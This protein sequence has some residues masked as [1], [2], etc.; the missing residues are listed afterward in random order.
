VIELDIDIKP[1]SDSN[2]INFK[3][4]DVIPVAVLTTDDFNAADVDASAVVFGTGE[5]TI[6]HKKVHMEDVDGDGDTDMVL[7]FRTQAADLA[8]DDEEACLE[9]KTNV[10]ELIAGCDVVTVK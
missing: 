4:K 10:G 1:G 6:A 8:K 9:G 5:A 3:S 7:H 2:P